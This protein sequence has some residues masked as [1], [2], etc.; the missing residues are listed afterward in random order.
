[1][2]I[3][4]L[5]EGTVRQ[6]GSTL[7]IT[8]PVVLLKELLDN[9][10]DSGATSIDVLV[11]LNAIDRIEVRD[12]GHGIQQDD[13]DSLGR[14]GHTSK[15]R[16]FG[17]LEKLGGR[18]LGFRG[19]ALASANDL[20]DISLT[21]R[22][23]AEQ[24]ATVITLAKGG[25]IGSQRHASAPVGTTVCATGLFSNLPV[26]RQVSI[27]EAP[28]YLARMKELLQAYALARHWIRLRFTV[29]KTPNLS[30]SYVPAANGG[31]K[32]AAMQLFSTEL[33]SQCIFEVYSSKDHR[34][35]P[36]NTWSGLDV[37]DE[38]TCPVFEALLPRRAADPRKIGKSAFI[39]VD[40]RPLSPARGTAKKLYVIFKECLGDHSAHA[41][42]TDLPKDPFI[43][44]N[45][46]CPL[47]YYDVNVETSKDDVVF[48]E[49]QYIFDRFRSFLSGIYSAPEDQAPAKLPLEP[50][51]A[52]DADTPNGASPQYPEATQAIASPWRVDMSTGLD[53]LSDDENDIE[54]PPQQANQQG[55]NENTPTASNTKADKDDD[56]QR[57]KEGLNPWS[58]AKL[59]RQHQ[60]HEPLPSGS[61]QE[62]HREAESRPCDTAVT[63]SDEGPLPSRQQ[64]CP[65]ERLD[66]RILQPSSLG[67]TEQ[68]I[69][70]YT[71]LPKTTTFATR[72]RRQGGLRAHRGP[73]SP[74]SSSPHGHSFDEVFPRDSAQCRPLQPTGRL[75]QARISFNR[76]NR[77][78][79]HLSPVDPG[80]QWK[81]PNLFRLRQNEGS[82]TASHLPGANIVDNVT[83]NASATGTSPRES[84]LQEPGPRKSTLRDMA[85]TV[86]VDG[87]VYHKDRQ[88]EMG[89]RHNLSTQD[90]REQL[91]RQQCF[92]AENPQKKPR[93]LK[94]EQLPLETIP[95]DFQTFTL[96]LTIMVD[97][98]ELTQRLSGAARYDTYLVDGELRDGFGDG[99]S[100]EDAARLAKSLLERTN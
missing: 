44:L 39:S 78:Q 11:S 82:S 14:P 12:N 80:N 83:A 16:S 9:A 49:E 7:V 67:D 74:P 57:S 42:S 91:A 4:A 99:I 13:F 47:G 24:V 69:F 30:W 88:N 48:R 65:T 26:R 89:S 60:R 35:G 51:T 45:V 79:W 85:N 41:H 71:Q 38:E 70:E 8:N 72:S 22:A 81:F 20:A 34:T 37:S 100:P 19:A 52:M 46:R 86:E 61:I 93:R 54:H 27:K 55:T 3:S 10:I 32:E 94:T 64:T 90:P 29:L 75:V 84:R 53:G 17:E 68:D 62:C 98:S 21:T 76:G 66:H 36:S 95:R 6:L 5:P 40:S 56:R 96:L 1:M 59:A 23:S 63:A 15:L 25:G 43:S 73:R 2:P 33:A 97:F 50:T 92:M 87:G 31:V 58:I 28:K 77:R 18:T